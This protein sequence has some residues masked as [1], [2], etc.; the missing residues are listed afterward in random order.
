MRERR[1]VSPCLLAAALVAGCATTVTPVEKDVPPEEEALSLPPSPQKASFRL[2]PLVE[3][4]RLPGVAEVGITLGGDGRVDLLRGA[5]PGA[6]GEV[7][8]YVVQG[9]KAEDKGVVYRHGVGTYPFDLLRGPADVVDAAVPGHDPE[10][11]ARLLT[12]EDGAWK[13]GPALPETTVLGDMRLLVSGQDLL[14][15]YVATGESA[16][17]PPRREFAAGL[18]EGLLRFFERADKIALAKRSGDG[19]QRVAVVDRTNGHEAKRFRAVSGRNGDVHIL[20]VRDFTRLASPGTEDYE[21]EL[22]YARIPAGAAEAEGVRLAGKPDWRCFDVAAD[23]DTGAAM[24]AWANEGGEVLA[25]TVSPAGVLGA[26]V[27]LAEGGDSRWHHADVSLAAVGSGRFLVATLRKPPATVEL[28]LYDGKTWSA[29]ETV[30]PGTGL[31]GA[32]ARDGGAAVA[33]MN[34]PFLLVRRVELT[35]TV[36]KK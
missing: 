25:R 32:T 7:R 36:A 15:A 16:G 8:H 9:D 34:W 30:G 27:R 19:W 11:P 35:A 26:P 13:E 18:H 1:K 24:L 22:A 14:V 21:E 3:A 31:F 12:L 4:G 29:A 6:W 28:R 23:P 17:A 33:W 20:Y 5:G 10:D 2:G